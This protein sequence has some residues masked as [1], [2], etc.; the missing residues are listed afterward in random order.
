MVCLADRVPPALEAPGERAVEELG[1]R[2]L[3]LHLELA[4]LDRN[5]NM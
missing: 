1:A 2:A 4:R 3:Q 5:R